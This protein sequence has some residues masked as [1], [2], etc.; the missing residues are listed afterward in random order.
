VNLEFFQ[1]SQTKAGLSAVYLAES[2]VH[3]LFGREAR[4]VPREDAEVLR[5]LA[6]GDQTAFERIYRLYK[7]DLFTATIFFLCGDWHAAEDVL[8][9]VFVS[10]AKASAS[11]IRGS[12]RNYLI[13]SCLNR[14]RD[15]LRQGRRTEQ[16]AAQQDP[17]QLTTAFDPSSV[18]SA[19]EDVART[20]AALA[21]LPAEQRE[22]VVL[23]IYGDMQFHEIAE[24]LSISINT[25]QSRYRYAIAALR[26][27]L[28]HLKDEERI[29]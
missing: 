19:K 9:D 6:R 23:R 14:A 10:L 17:K 5:A 7:D 2:G 28:A 13:T 15:Y 18:L 24:S 4:F 1:I 22:V 12:L 16:L 29:P 8:H 3:P 11:R 26:K 21:Q 27:R 20:I 25:A